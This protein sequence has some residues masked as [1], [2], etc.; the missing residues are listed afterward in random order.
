MDARDIIA[1]LPI[2]EWHG[3]F[4]TAL[5]GQAIEGL[6]AGRGLLLAHLP[7]RIAPDE[8]FLLSPSVMG[9]ER[10]NISFE[11]ALHL[12]VTAMARPERSPLRVPESLAGRALA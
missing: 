12:P 7:F 2:T 3:P 4:D 9:S 1:A 5:P 11:Q 6:E 8:L 10:K